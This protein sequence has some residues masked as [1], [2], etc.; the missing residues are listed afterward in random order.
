MDHQLT[1]IVRVPTRAAE[2][3]LEVY[4]HIS[5]PFIVEEETG[6]LASITTPLPVIAGDWNTK[7]RFRASTIADL[8]T[9][10]RSGEFILCPGGNINRLPTE[11][12]EVSAEACT[13]ALYT[14]NY[15]GVNKACNFR[16][17]LPDHHVVPLGNNEYIGFD[18][19]EQQATISCLNE[20]HDDAFYV[21]PRFR[22]ALHDGCVAAWG[23]YQVHSDDTLAQ[24]GRREA[25]DWERTP[26]ETFGLTTSELRTLARTYEDRLRSTG[27]SRE[28]LKELAA[29][30]R[31]RSALTAVAYFACAGTALL[32]LTITI[33]AAVCYTKTTWVL[34]TCGRIAIRAAD[35]AGHKLLR[36]AK[37]HYHRAKERE[38]DKVTVQTAC[39]TC[40]AK[41]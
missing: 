13:W 36:H 31:R 18:G 38:E 2:E 7:R 19:V 11:G 32:L 16:L 6:L 35:A 21:G 17:H 10:S 8:L 30:L 39:D 22:F 1:V 27:I 12:D 4:R 9:C 14:A 41:D 5:I 25:Y 40:S 28:E 33:I 26:E 15:D 23:S 34:R 29:T 37:A 20:K 24:H 3:E